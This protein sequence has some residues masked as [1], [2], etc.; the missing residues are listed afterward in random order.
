MREKRPADVFRARFDALSASVPRECA[1]QE[2]SSNMEV[3]K[4]RR[5]TNEAQ[6][7]RCKQS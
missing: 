4:T 6:R 7:D 5:K 1:N 2:K 3:R